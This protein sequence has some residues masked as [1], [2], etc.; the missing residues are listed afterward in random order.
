MI[1]LLI[2]N[3]FLC[4]GVQGATKENKILSFIPKLFNWF[5]DN[6]SNTHWFIDNKIKNENNVLIC[7]FW[8]IVGICFFVFSL[9]EDVIRKPLYACLQCMASIWGA[10]F[11]YFNQSYL[12]FDFWSIQTIGW[13]FALSG[14]NWIV[15]EIMT[16]VVNSRMVDE[17]EIEGAL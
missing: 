11:V 17:M 14:L 12:G 9:F 16:K 1:E 10:A 6:F 2:I 15:G 3:S 5:D 7:F 8:L 13:I 4:V